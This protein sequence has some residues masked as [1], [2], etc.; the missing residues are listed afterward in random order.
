MTMQDTSKKLQKESVNKQL[1]EWIKKRIAEV[2]EIKNG[3]YEKIHNKL[4]KKSI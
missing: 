4:F 3:Y 1:Q 2:P